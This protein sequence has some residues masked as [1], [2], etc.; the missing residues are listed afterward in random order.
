MAER[1]ELPLDL[2][3]AEQVLKALET[4]SAL[5]TDFR[6]EDDKKR[7]SRVALILRARIQAARM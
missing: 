2:E 7:L 4:R 3:E 6:E 1:I 5:M